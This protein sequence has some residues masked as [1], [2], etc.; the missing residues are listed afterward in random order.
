V[1][2]CVPITR[3]IKSRGLRQVGH[4]ARVAKMRNA[5]KIFVGK[6]EEKRPLEELGV[7]GR[8]TLECMLRSYGGEVWTGLDAA[9]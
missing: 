5:Y 6:P 7:V 4:L 3:V 1:I 8:I 2:L 9:G